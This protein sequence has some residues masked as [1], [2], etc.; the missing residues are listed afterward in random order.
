MTT[1]TALAIATALL[2]LS[3]TASA[4][5]VP[6]AMDDRA[7]AQLLSGPHGTAVRRFAATAAVALHCGQDPNPHVGAVMQALRTRSR[8]G[9]EQIALL[10]RYGEAV[11][12]QALEQVR[13]VPC[14]AKLRAELERRKRED[15]GSLR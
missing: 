2:S 9:E 6:P 4:Q 1:R 13:S 5:Q 8:L 11:A 14:D 10:G 7:M 15:L 3:G 12:Q